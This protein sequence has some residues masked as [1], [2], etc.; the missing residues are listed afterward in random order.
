MKD[1]QSEFAELD[2]GS[3]ELT[4]DCDHFGLP[5][6]VFP[7]LDHLREDM[8]QTASAWELYN[9]FSASLSTVKKEDWISFRGKQHNRFHERCKSN[10]DLADRPA[11]RAGG[12]RQGVAGQTSR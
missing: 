10:F 8:T 1:W 12:Y 3:Q 4:Q 7:A 6:P 11:V 5:A 9:E 2:K